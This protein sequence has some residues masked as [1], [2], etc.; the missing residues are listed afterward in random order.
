M[1]LMSKSIF[2]LLVFNFAIVLFS[3]AQSGKLASMPQKLTVHQG[4]EFDLLM[5]VH[6][7]TEPVSVVDL[8]LTFDTIFVQAVSIN[9]IN[10]PLGVNQIEPNINSKKGIVSYAAF[11]LNSPPDTPFQLVSV[12]FKAINETPDTRIYHDLKA[13]FKTTLAF[14]GRDNLVFAPDIEITILPGIEN[15]ASSKAAGKNN[16]SLNQQIENT[17]QIDFSVQELGSAKLRL[18]N[19]KDKNE[20][21]LYEN[22]AAPEMSYTQMVDVSVLPSG[23]YQLLL[24]INGSKTI[25]NFEI[26][27]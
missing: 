27:N 16:L 26:S 12:R 18:V 8:F 15:L 21:V 14:A 24:E 22:F 25:Q 10:S 1:K 6:P 4:Q 2:C 9:K 11:T 19:E 17:L 3:F 13:V 7:G 20:Y 5:Y 23:K